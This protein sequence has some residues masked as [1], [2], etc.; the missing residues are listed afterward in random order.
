MQTVT[1]LTFTGSA[2]LAGKKLRNLHSLC[3]AGKNRWLRGQTCCCWFLDGPRFY[4]SMLHLQGIRVEVNGQ[5]L[6]QGGDVT[7]DQV[8]GSCKLLPK[9]RMCDADLAYTYSERQSGPPPLR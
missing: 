5:V 8:S 2:L 9:A 1:N 3:F 7:A 4:T 6:S